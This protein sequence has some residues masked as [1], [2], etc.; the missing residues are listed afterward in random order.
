MRADGIATALV[1]QL[2]NA[3][4]VLFGVLMPLHYDWPDFVHTDYGFPFVWATH[5]T[6]TIAGPADKWTLSLL[7]LTLNIV[8]GMVISLVFSM[9]VTWIYTRHRPVSVRPG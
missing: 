3:G 1:A 5:T 2:F 6:V 7:S 4:L 9:V 8:I